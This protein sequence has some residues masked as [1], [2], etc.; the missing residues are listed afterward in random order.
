MN[1]I[2][3]RQIDQTP[4]PDRYARGWHCLGL[5]TTF[6]D[7]PS[8][9]SA[10]GTRIVV[11]RDSAGQAIVLE[12][13]CPHMGGDLTMGKV[14]GD[15]VRCPY[16]DW[17]W[18]AEGM[19][20]DI[21]YAKK[22]PKNARIKSWPVCEENQLLFIW[23]DPEGM[24]PSPDE[25][26][27]PEDACLADDWSDWVIEENVIHINCRELIDNMSDKAHFIT[28]HGLKAPDLFQ[29]IFEGH[30]LTQIMNA[31]NDVGSE[32]GEGGELRASATYYGPAYM[33]AAIDNEAGGFSEEENKAVVAEYTTMT[34]LSFKQDVDIWHNKFRVDNPLLCDGDGPL[35][36]LREWYNQFY[37]DRDQVPK[38]LETR[39][40]YT[41]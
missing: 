12:A 39:K 22:I 9:I 40:E 35:H 23:N 1:S 11:F 28:V 2:P 24:P 37:I 30:R 15:V 5:S 19:C 16:H 6:T 17:G 18:G 7:E 8:A 26:V 3:I 32:F 36:K 10:F 34:Q 29:N 31:V 4:A 38:K 21:P 25:I 13:I 33:I 27:P 14:D 20:L 41:V